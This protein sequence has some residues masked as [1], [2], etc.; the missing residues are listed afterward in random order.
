MSATA[1]PDSLPDPSVFLNEWSP[2]TQLAALHRLWIDANADPAFELN[3]SNIVAS[4]ISDQ[5][6]NI[7]AD[8]T[9]FNAAANVAIALSHKRFIVRT[10]RR[11]RPAFPHL[12]EHAVLVHD[13]SKLTNMLE[14]VGYTQKWVHGT[15]EPQFWDRA[16]QHHFAS[17]SHHPEFYAVNGLLMT[18]SE[19][20]LEESVVDM[21]AIQ[22]ERVFAGRDDVTGGQLCEIQPRYLE[23]YE[24][25]DRAR[26]AEL[27]NI[28][29]ALP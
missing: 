13:N 17:N 12:S 15:V 21:L 22:W 1:L 14:M 18:M 8:P 9:A 20:D 23:R 2:D 3:P 27:L 6:Y 29:R 7:L 25:G 28:I 26:V 5:D 10:F 4:R 11:F 19:S 24:V 16:L